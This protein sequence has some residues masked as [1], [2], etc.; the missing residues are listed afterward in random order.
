M[1]LKEEGFVEKIRSWWVSF[2]FVGSP[3]FVL[4]KKLRA[5]KG[6]LKRWTAY[7]CFHI[8]NV[9]DFLGLLSFS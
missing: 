6:E 2:S 9:L 8:S 5:L 4:A 3:I 1:W 7:S